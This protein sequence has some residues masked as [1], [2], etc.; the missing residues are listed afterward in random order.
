MTDA[1]GYAMT[2]AM[3]DGKPQAGRA[4]TR[5]TREPPMRG[6]RARSVAE[7]LPAVG[8]V[9][10]RK[11]GFVQSSVVSRWRE[12]VGERYAAISTPESIRFPR[13]SRDGGVLHLSVAAAHAPMLQHAAPA[14]IDRVNR[15]FGY[16]AV[17]RMTIRQDHGLA[18]RRAASVPV[19]KEVPVALGDSLRAIADPELKAVLESLARGL[20]SSEGPPALSGGA[21]D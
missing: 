11:F 6:G 18:P 4:R 2:R 14:I 16:A 10:F 20:A 1:I 17:G 21:R 19:V 12:I 5:A 7:M 8:G 9:A 15:F 13:N 3:K